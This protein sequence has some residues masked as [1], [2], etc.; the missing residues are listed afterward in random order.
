MS[1][2]SDKHARARTTHTLANRPSSASHVS[3]LSN[4]TS[5]AQAARHSSPTAA[6]R[7]QGWRHGREEQERM[8]KNQISTQAMRQKWRAMKCCVPALLLPKASRCC[9]RRHHGRFRKA[10]ARCEAAEGALQKRSDSARCA[11][12]NRLSPLLAGRSVPPRA[13]AAVL[14]DM[15]GTPGLRSDTRVRGFCLMFCFFF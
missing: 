15:P 10:S 12:T 6:A 14:R 1:A 9:A 13:P 8:G 4:D 2:A 5:T 7:G 11:S 3:R